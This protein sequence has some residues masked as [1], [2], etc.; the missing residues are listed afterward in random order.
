MKHAYIDKYSKLNSIIHQLDARVK[1]ISLFLFVFF[2]IF[3]RPTQFYTFILYGIVITLLFLLSKIP[4]SFI[5]KRSLVVIPFV[6]MVA[7]FIPF[8]K[9][10]EI[11][12]GYSFGSLKLT[13]TYD[14]LIVFWN[15]LVKAYLCILIMI[16]LTASTS[17]S[18][19]LK[20]FEKLKLPPIFIMILSFM[21]RYIFVVQDELMKMIQAKEARTIG[22][23]TPSHIKVFTNMIGILFMRAYERAEAVYLAM[24]SRG[25][26]GKIRTVSSFQL[27]RKDFYFLLVM[28][29]ILLGIKMFGK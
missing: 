17:F 25:F 9:K 3:T 26:E 14:G 20:A 8:L 16:L 15:I 12:G 28:I 27:K 22:G 21:Y 1:I 6:L 10:G 7:L 29:S 24:C 23:S 4:P 18:E 2:V 19:L 11:A 5:F 13:I